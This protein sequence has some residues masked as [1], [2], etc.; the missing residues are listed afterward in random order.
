MH[1]GYC[2]SNLWLQVM[3]IRSRSMFEKVLVLA[4]SSSVAEQCSGFLF[5]FR[6]CWCAVATRKAGPRLCLHS[7]CS[8]IMVRS[9]FLAC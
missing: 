7:R 6:G 5:S 4:S 1:R 3:R 9:E 8:F 2:Q